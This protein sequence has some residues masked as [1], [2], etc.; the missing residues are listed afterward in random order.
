MVLLNKICKITVEKELIFLPSNH[1]NILRPKPAKL[2][3]KLQE[4]PSALN[5]EHPTL[6][7]HT[8]FT[9]LWVFLPLGPD[10]HSQ[11]I[12]GSTTYVAINLSFFELST[13]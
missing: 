6:L 1:C 13:P 4:R 2:V 3:L 7:N 11:C 8:L 12:S 10:S 9:F 5:K